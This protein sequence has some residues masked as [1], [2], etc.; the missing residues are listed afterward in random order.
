MLVQA[1]NTGEGITIWPAVTEVFRVKLLRIAGGCLD[2]T[3]E[4]KILLEEF[5]FLLVLILLIPTVTSIQFYLSRI[6]FFLHFYLLKTTTYGSFQLHETV[7]VTD[8]YS[9]IMG[10]FAIVS[11]GYSLPCYQWGTT[12]WNSVVTQVLKKYVVEKA[13]KWFGKMNDSIVCN[14]SR[15][16]EFSLLRVPNE[17]HANIKLPNVQSLKFNI[18]KMEKYGLLRILMKSL[19]INFTSHSVS[20][21]ATFY[22]G[23]CG[24]QLRASPY[25]VLLPLD[26]VCFDQILKEVCI[27]NKFCS[28]FMDAKATKTLQH[29]CNSLQLAYR[30]QSQLEECFM[31]QI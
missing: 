22:H 8:W 28:N 29:T 26:V 14:F 13:Q 27:P 10:L 21:V 4:L 19:Q 30:Q 1:G 7:L 18:N 15:G 3:H 25:L 5:I 11:T 6:G 16:A 2:E 12:Y 31:S 23:V 9:K 20:T 17:Y 24:V